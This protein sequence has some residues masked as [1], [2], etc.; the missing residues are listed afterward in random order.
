MLDLR[1][2]VILSLLALSLL[3]VL[4]LDAITSSLGLPLELQGTPT[5]P[6][7]V[8]WQHQFILHTFSEEFDHAFQLLLVS[9][10]KTGFALPTKLRTVDRDRVTALFVGPMEGKHS[11][12]GVEPFLQASQVDAKDGPVKLFLTPPRSC[13]LG[14]TD[15]HLILGQLPRLEVDWALRLLCFDLFLRLHLLVFFLLQVLLLLLKI[16]KTFRGFKPALQEGAKHSVHH[17][18]RVSSD[19]RSEVR[20]IVEVQ[21]KVMRIFRIFR[22]LILLRLITPVDKVLSLLHAS[23]HCHHFHT[24]A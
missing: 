19:G 14:V 8:V 10:A 1:R 11:S 15:A 2:P 16:L 12:H 13:F 21:C 20:V 24:K 23:T 18:I 17:D 3:G 22:F 4:G 7:P 6:L 5:L 9:F